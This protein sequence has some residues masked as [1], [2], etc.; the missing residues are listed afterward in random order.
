MNTP[1]DPGG[2]FFD[3]FECKH[4]ELVALPPDVRKGFAFPACSFCFTR[5]RLLLGR[6]SLQNSF[7]WDAARKGEAFPHIGRQSRSCTNTRRL[8]FHLKYFRKSFDD[9]IFYFA[10]RDFVIE[11]FFH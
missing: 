2:G 7:F 5:L 1:G 3:K 6:P 4:D 9:A 11:D 8:K 10:H